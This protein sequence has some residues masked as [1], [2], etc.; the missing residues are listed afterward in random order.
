MKQ[1]VIENPVINFPYLEPNRHFKF[2]DDGITDEIVETRRISSYFIPIA[3]P[4]KK[5]KSDQLSFETE[6][7]QD[8][9]EENKL[10]NQIRGTPWGQA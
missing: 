2:S 4:K 7:T 3:K 5:G 10:I 6:W 1:V 9:F 8:R